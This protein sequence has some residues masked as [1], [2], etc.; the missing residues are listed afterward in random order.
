ML[1]RCLRRFALVLAIAQ[2]LIST[3]F[4]LGYDGLLWE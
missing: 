3:A 4:R 1:F 2:P